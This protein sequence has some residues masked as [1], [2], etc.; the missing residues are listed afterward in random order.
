MHDE[1]EDRLRAGLA[2][3]RD[4]AFAALYDCY[5]RSLY[6]VAWT[7]LRSRHD[8]E[9]AVQEVFLGIARS[10]ANL[11]CVKNLR[12]YLFSALRHA[13]TRMDSKRKPDTLADE[14][15]PTS[16]DVGIDVE[17]S[18]ALERG[19]AVLPVEQREV[20]SLKI[21]GELTFAE[22]AAVLEISLNTAASRYRYALEKL[23][24]V[25]DSEIHGTRTTA[26]RPA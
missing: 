11:D 4:D 16:S 13:V 1:A 3:G 25:I 12:A 6:R 17:L 7:M 20:L 24:S 9:D 15:P 10:Y 18:A 19:L 5:G 2:A 26:T 21:D 23:R 22:I 14:E 8:A